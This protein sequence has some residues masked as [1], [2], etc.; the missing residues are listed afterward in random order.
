MVN[1]YEKKPIIIKY[2][3][4]FD[5]INKF[6]LKEFSQNYLKSRPIRNQTKRIWHHFSL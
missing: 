3:K 1:Q 2:S 5:K 6:G 4:T